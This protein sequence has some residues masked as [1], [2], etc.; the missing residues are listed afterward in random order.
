MRCLNCLTVVADNDTTCPS[1]RAPISPAKSAQSAKRPRPVFALIFM[2]MGSGI[3]NVYYP[4]AS[5]AA[6]T[7]G[8]ID[9]QR[10]LYAGCVG[11]VCAVF[12]GLIDHFL[13]AGRK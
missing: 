5:S 11:A 4:A 3:Y 7:G 2:V 1:C 9:F 10:C 6:K 8:G 12:G 13:N